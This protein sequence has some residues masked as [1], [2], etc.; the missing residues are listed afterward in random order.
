VSETAAA[1]LELFGR[2]H[3]V[4]LHLPIGLLAGLGAMELVALARRKPNPREVTR[5]LIGVAAVFTLM[6]AATGY[7]LGRETTDAGNIV[8]RHQQL[9]I[10]LA[11]A[12][13][14]TACVHWAS[15]SVRVYRIALLITLALLIPVGHLGGSLTHGE[16]YV[17]APLARVLRA[18]AMALDPQS[19]PEQTMFAAAETQPAQ[20]IAAKPVSPEEQV[21]SVVQVAQ[22]AASPEDDFTRHVQPILKTAC[23]ECHGSSRQK[24][25]LALHSLA[26]LTAGGRSGSVFVAGKPD[27][28]EIVRRLRLP[29]GD[30]KRMPPAGKTPLSEEQIRTIEAWIESRELASPQPERAV[31][32]QATVSRDEASSAEQTEVPPPP[33]EPKS[34]GTVVVAPPPPPDSAALQALAE[35]LVHFE[36][37]APGS[38]LLLI[39]FAAAANRTDD[40][41]AERLLT[42]LLANLDTVSLSGCNVGDK[43]VALLA[44]A[45]HLRRL[46]L[47]GTSTTDAGAAA[48]AKLPQ[49]GELVLVRTKLTDAAVAHLAAMPALQRVHVWGSGLSDRAV[50]DLR[51]CRPELNVDAGDSPLAVAQEVEPE[52]KLTSDAPPPAP[53]SASAAPA[54]AVTPAVP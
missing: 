7:V 4:V 35:H 1:W 53:P 23:V 34:S 27:E 32:A 49:L 48:I 37:A 19:P 40:A 39:D 9:G 2:L 18:T 12:C 20:A 31:L 15:T 42:P 41:A 11:I 24:G 26:A 50:A 29:E 10:A 38:N 36:A 28:S 3:P 33:L 25:G 44:S 21:A 45:P 52:I 16:S 17:S 30:R 6:A 46:D 8:A 5:V 13:G 14:L 54:A 47:R 51:S 22:P 43:T